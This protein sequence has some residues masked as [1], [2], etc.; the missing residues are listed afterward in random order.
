MAASVAVDVRPRN[1]W[2]SPSGMVSFAAIVTGAADTT[3]TWSVQEATGC[4][5]IS[6]SGVYTAPAAP[7]TCHVVASLDKY[8][9]T[10]G[11]IPVVTAETA[12]CATEPLRT[13][14]TV[15]YYCACGPGSDAACVPGS[16]ANDGLSA[17]RPRQT[18]PQDK[19]KTLQAGQ[20]VALCR[21]G[22]FDFVDT[23][24]NNGQCNS[25]TN[26]CD[27]RDYT[28]PARPEWAT[29]QT[30]RPIINGPRVFI[31]NSGSGNASSRGLRFW[32]LQARSGG[33][34]IAFFQG[35]SGSVVTQD[36]D[37]CNVSMADAAM[38]V[39]FG[40]GPGWTVRHS[41]FE[42][43]TGQGT[44]GACTDCA[45][46][47]NYFAPDSYGQKSWF[48]HAIYIG[49]G[50]DALHQRFSVTNNEI[51]GCPSPNAATTGTP[52]VTSHGYVADLLFE[53]NLV[54]CDHPEALTSGKD[55]MV[56]FETTDGGYAPNRPI[57]F[58]RAMV[59]RN[60]FIGFSTGISI[61]VAPDA[62]IED[63]IVVP[64]SVATNDTTGIEVKSN[65]RDSNDP[66]SDRVIVRN[67]TVYA[68]AFAND[69]GMTGFR[70]QREEQLPSSGES[71]TNNVVYGVNPATTTC[72]DL[73]T[74]HNYGLL[75]SNACNGKWNT[76]LDTN[77]VTLAASPFVSGGTNFIPAEGSALVNAGSTVS[78]A[79]LAI[80]SA[81]WSAGDI[82]KARDTQPDIGAFER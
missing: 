29:D 60:R 3:V 14:G 81:A 2:V 18:N 8:G 34:G 28:P 11:P 6:P 33:A 22:A 26:T 41:Q 59:R 20:T 62:V 68:P 9:A 42:R 58:P 66:V 16:D 21:G 24:T 7:A 71:F 37:I 45:I 72:F 63:N 77:R 13:S 36:V 73:V 47:H 35:S 74:P 15:F 67:N 76:T 4:G 70:V 39:F 43:L 49:G 27:L 80:G 19:F 48:N 10:S 65:V 69:V 79:S 5:S 57:G 75:S 46:D 31:A 25:A 50:V 23:Y 44:L 30:K 64:M 40:E 56:G 78:Y 55:N 17:E 12:R 52:L 1:A 53:N 54:Q 38:G 32:N 51:H 82:G 61:S